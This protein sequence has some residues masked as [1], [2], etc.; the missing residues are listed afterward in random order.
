MTRVITAAAAV[1]AM[2]GTLAAVPGDVAAQGVNT[3]FLISEID[4]RTPKCRDHP[5]APVVGRVS[6]IIG[7]SPSRGVSFQ[8][9]F[10]NMRACERWRGPVSGRISGRIIQNSC[11]ARF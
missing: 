10:D 1:L 5:D 6:G 7:G 9:C 4:A 3:Q 8:G 11:Q 2:A